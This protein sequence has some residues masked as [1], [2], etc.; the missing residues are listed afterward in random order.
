MAGRRRRDAE[1]DQGV[2]VLLGELLG[3]V[4]GPAELLR[5][6][7]DV[8]GRHDEHDR[9]RVAA[10]AIRAAPRPMH[11]AVSR[12]IGSPTIVVGRQVRAAAAG[13]SSR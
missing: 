3:R 2:G 12:P 9:V 7:D 10:R 1:G 5:R 11:A 8:V 6:L 4:D 13:A